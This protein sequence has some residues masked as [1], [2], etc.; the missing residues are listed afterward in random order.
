[1]PASI[2]SAIPVTYLASSEARY[3]MACETASGSIRQQ[4]HG[5]RREHDVAPLLRNPYHVRAPL[6][7]GPARDQCDRPVETSGHAF[8][9]CLRADSCWDAAFSRIPRGPEPGDGHGTHS[10]SAEMVGARDLVI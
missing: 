6:A 4:V 1:M 10:D 8:L 9:L 3:T 2:G 7:T 5:L